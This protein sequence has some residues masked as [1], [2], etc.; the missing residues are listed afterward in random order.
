MASQRKQDV[1]ALLADLSFESKPSTASVSPRSTHPRAPAKGEDVQSLLDD[2]EGLVQ[3]RRS[4]G[5]A[6]EATAAVSAHASAERP[7]SG[8]Q[9]P[10]V[11][12]AR[13]PSISGARTPNLSATR[14]PSR[15]AS[16]TP[17][18]ND[19]AP[20]EPK[21]S[22]AAPT[23]STVPQAAPVAATQ[24]ASAAAAP[25]SKAAAPT[26][27][28]TTDSTL[29][30]W[31]QWG[32]SWFSNATRIADQARHELERR[33]AAVVQ[34]APPMDSG[35]QQ[36]IQDI[37]NRFAERFRGLVKEAGL[38]SLGQNLTAAGRRGWSDI[39]NAVAPPMEAHESVDVTLSHGTLCIPHLIQT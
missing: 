36:P 15:F 3:R 6:R 7:L 8:K 14:A 34:K 5:E 19:D 38:D 12:G 31:G 29:S 10:S 9:T 25:S 32:G 1:D 2:L 18:S 35:V 37:G 23:A 39:V 27:S 26:E 30:S 22:P 20:Q 24:E 21:Q 16:P 11:S 33:A 13:T 28:A 17:A 4:H